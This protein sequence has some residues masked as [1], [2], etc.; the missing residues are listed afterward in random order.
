MALTFI[1]GSSPAWADAEKT[2]VTLLAT[3]EEIG[4]V[5]FTADENDVEEHGRAIY[6]LAIAEEFGPVAPYSAPAISVPAI[7]SDRQFFQQ[8]A[9]QGLITQAEALSAVKIGALPATLEGLVSLLP[10]E[11]QFPARMMLSGATQFERS[12]PLT[13]VIGAAQGLTPDQVDALWVAA[14]QL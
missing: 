8:L 9:N 7:I 10:A 5:P 13:N 2:R 3:F 11:Q 12:H 4:E 6:A 1:S 14:S